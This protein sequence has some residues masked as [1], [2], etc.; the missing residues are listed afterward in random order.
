MRTTLNLLNYG[1][2]ANLVSLRNGRRS[3]LT[4]ICFPRRVPSGFPVR[5]ERSHPLRAGFMHHDTALAYFVAQGI[6]SDKH[7]FSES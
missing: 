4:S 3:S 1:W 7:Q 6:F 2:S 5:M